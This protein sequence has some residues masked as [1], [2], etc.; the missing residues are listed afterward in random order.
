[1]IKEMEKKL[2]IMKMEKLNIIQNLKMIKLKVKRL[3]IIKMEK[4]KMKWN[5]KMVTK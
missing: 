4:L 3:N 1:M 5:I 2:D